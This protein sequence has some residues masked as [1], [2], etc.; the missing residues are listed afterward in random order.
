[1]TMA[2]E[3]LKQIDNA[4]DTIRPEAKEYVTSLDEIRIKTTKDN[5]GPVLAFLGKLKEDAGSDMAP[6]FLIAMVGAGYPLGTAQQLRSL[7]G[8]P[9]TVDALLTREYLKEVAA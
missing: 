7:L 6:L 1:M 3:A 9:M 5:Y 4:L 8:F 2:P